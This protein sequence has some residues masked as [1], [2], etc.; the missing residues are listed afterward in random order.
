MQEMYGLDAEVILACAMH[1]LG[2][3]EGLQLYGNRPNMKAVAFSLK[4]FFFA[5]SLSLFIVFT[6]WLTYWMMMK[7][8]CV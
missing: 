8:S 6:L 4:Y 5:L 7:W 2:G 3:A 1:V